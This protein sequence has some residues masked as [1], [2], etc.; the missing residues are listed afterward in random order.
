M[1]IH[2][3]QLG[4]QLATTERIFRPIAES[5]TNSAAFENVVVEGAVIP[6]HQHGHEELIICLEG[7]AECTFAGSAPELYTVGSVVVIPPNTRHTITN[8]GPGQLRQLSFFSG[9]E[10]GTVWDADSGSVER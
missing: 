4:A 3:S 8:V 1:P 10:P 9:P 6:W 5:A 7:H 2:H